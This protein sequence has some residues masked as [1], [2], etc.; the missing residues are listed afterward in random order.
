MTNFFKKLLN[1]YFDSMSRMPH[2]AMWMF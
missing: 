1:A 2:Q